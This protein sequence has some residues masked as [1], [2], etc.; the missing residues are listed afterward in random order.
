[1]QVCHEAAHYIV[2]KLRNIKIGRPTPLPSPQL[3]T[4]GCITP[5]LSFPPN[6][7]ALFDFAFS[8]PVMGMAASLL[9][10]V[11]GIHLTTHATDIVLSRFPVL[12]VGIFK[13]SL[14]TGMLLSWFAPKTMMLPL[15]QPL[16]LHPLFLSGFVGLISSALNLLPIFRLDGG[17]IAYSVFGHRFLG[18]ASATSLLFMLSL[19]MSGTSSIALTWGLLV[20]VLQRRTE[21]PVR[22]DVTPVDD[23][24]L[25]A[26]VA[27]LTMSLL[28]LAP[29]PGGPGFL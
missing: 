5:I 29:F 16:P 20:T 10:M 7:A 17:R 9:M 1:M 25:G 13:S 28:A 11:G 22:D 18:I 3:G 15:A 27:S 8:G 24:R 4:F 19:T 14:L 26:W 21:V 12:P 2:A 6:R 23:F